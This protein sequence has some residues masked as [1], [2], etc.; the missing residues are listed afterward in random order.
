MCGVIG[1][2]CELYVLCFGFMLFYMCF[3]DVWDV[4]EMLCDIFVIDVWKVFE[5]VECGVVI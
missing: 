1:D 3:V 2:Y 5:F 4:V